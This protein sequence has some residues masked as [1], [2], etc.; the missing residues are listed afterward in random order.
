MKAKLDY[1]YRI[2]KVSLRKEH[3]KDIEEII[4]KLTKLSLEDRKIILNL[5]DRMLEKNSLYVN[6]S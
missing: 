3:F 6:N 2:N 5:I 4:L 1:I